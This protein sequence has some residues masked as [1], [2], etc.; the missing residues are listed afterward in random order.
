MKFGKVEGSCTTAKEVRDSYRLHFLKG[1]KWGLEGF[2]T[3][4]Y[5]QIGIGRKTRFCGTFGPGSL[6]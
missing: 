6:S 2:I 4:T 5:I 3:R 1:M